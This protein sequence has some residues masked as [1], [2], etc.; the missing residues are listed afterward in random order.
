MKTQ[1]E[2]RSMHRILR[3][4]A[5]L[6]VIAMAFLPAFPDEGD[7][8]PP[9]ADLAPARIRALEGDATLQRQQEQDVVEATVNSPLYP[10][11]GIQ[12]GDGRVEV[13]FPDGSVLWLDSH[14]G[15]EV[16]GIRNPGA[17]SADNTVLRL[18]SGA[19]EMDYRGA[20]ASSNED[21]RIDTPESSV[22]LMGRGRFRVESNREATT[23]VSL[24][25]VAELAGDSGSVLVRS[26][27]RSSVQRDAV[28]DSPVAVN[29]L[30]P[31][32]FD[33]W[34]EE[35][36]A[37]YVSEDE[38]EDRQYVQ[39]V[40]TP[41]RHYVTELDNYGDWQWMA[42]FGWV[43]RPTIYQVGWRPYYNGYWS[44]APYGWTWVAYEPW[45]WAPYH[46]G[47]WCYIGSTGWVWIPGAVYAGAWVSWAVTPTYV[48]WCPLD[49]YNRPAYVS[50]HVTNVA[51]A[52]YGGG[53]N[54]L[55]L[56][57]FTDRGAARIMVRSDRVPNLQGAITTRTLPRFSPDQ[58][59]TRPD[60]GRQVVRDSS[61]HQFQLG[62]RDPG[63]RESGASFR[64]S[65]RRE[66]A[67]W[68]G[69]RRERLAP[70]DRP[71]TSVPITPRKAIEPAPR[72]R[73]PTG[74][75]PGVQDPHS[76]P[77]PARTPPGG[78]GRGEL[79][80][81]S[82]EG[83][84]APGSGGAAGVPLRRPSAGRQE[85]MEVRPRRSSSGPPATQD[86]RDAS[87]R[88]LD[89]IFGGNNPA[90]PAPTP[91][92]KATV[93]G[94]GSPPGMRNQQPQRQGAPAPRVDPSKRQQPPGRP[95]PPPSKDDG[96]EKKDK[97]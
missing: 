20:G 32:D 8:P 71:G 92:G 88:V 14:T 4:S 82:R 72:P 10:G 35:R 37:G 22:Y 58:I 87:T 91:R 56:N 77:D 25:G 73:I 5:F 89:R 41:V 68:P 34:C 50:L 67:H 47:R 17:E 18:Q 27:Q 13:E 24:R 11:D 39:G 65:D 83:R 40:P 96:K 21:P 46:Y 38:G 63:G 51:A 54:F 45:G 28:P 31:D 59:R 97:P 44:W 42:S 74:K 6:A 55:P 43:W 2:S 62:P 53:W 61:A 95:G 19:L 1:P 81:P 76:L 36:Q 90:G 78:R 84:F 48:G 12:T 33:Q 16:V 23:L 79:A 69:T 64:Q 94:G 85:G 52:P 80:R 15:V 57:R 26:G 93:P 86:S 49:F 3:G 60:L 70:A 7:D 29:T 30:R 9:G 75:S 66:L